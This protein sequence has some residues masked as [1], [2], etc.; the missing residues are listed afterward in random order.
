MVD[1]VIIE[2]GDEPEETA[3]EVEAVEIEAEAEAETA[4]TVA[5][6]SVEIAR[7]EAERDIVIA[8]IHAETEQARIE[9]VEEAVSGEQEESE[10][11]RNI[12]A[13]LSA[14]QE[15]MLDLAERLGS[16]TPPPPM[17]PENLEAPSNPPS[18]VEVVQE[19]AEPEAAQTPDEPP[20]RARKSHWI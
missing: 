7:I 1:T 12:E 3:S 13:N 14:M 18:E 10:W 19:A 9:A 16:L 8:E 15:T 4:E 17:Q 20:K 11:R 2:G 6:A 5:D